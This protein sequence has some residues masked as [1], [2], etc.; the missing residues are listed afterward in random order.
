M[1]P[2]ALLPNDLLD[3]FLS[4]YLD[5]QSQITCKKVCKHF[6]NIK[7]R[8]IPENLHAKLTNNILKQFPFLTTLYT[9]YNPNITD[10]GL[11]Y[12]PLLTTLDAKGNSNITSGDVKRIN[13]K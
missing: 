5:F 9:S 12:V 8:L 2:F 7:N 11:K 10:E 4:V 3:W 13:K 1:N 6:K